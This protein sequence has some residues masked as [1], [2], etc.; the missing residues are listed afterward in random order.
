VAIIAAVT[1][2]PKFISWLFNTV[3][4]T[5]PGAKLTKHDEV[6]WLLMFI[7]LLI[8]ATITD[9]CGT[10]LWGC[11]IA[12][13][14]FATQH[15]AHHVWVRQVKRTTC[16]WLRVFF[17]C[18]LAWSIPVDEL[19]SIDAFW[20]GSIMGIGPCIA[21]KVLCGPFMG[22]ARWVIGWAMVGRAEF[23][24]FIAILAKSLTLMDEKLFAILVWALIYATIF[25]P[26]I[27]RYV[28]V[29][30]MAKLEASEAPKRTSTKQEVEAEDIAHKVSQRISLGDA[31]GKLPNIGAEK[32]AQKKAEEQAE[33]TERQLALETELEQK[34]NRIKELEAKRAQ[35]ESDEKNMNDANAPE[36]P[37]REIT[38]D[39]AEI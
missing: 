15:H 37:P 2:W 24:Y 20:K 38:K 4:E 16:W 8:Y 23:A 39:L 11:F 9:V 10:H 32:L 35:L 5:K 7:T 34:N 27:F 18:T 29:G 19:F 14:S 26:L 21:T 22:D 3:K 25:A 6:M 31:H 12:G 13:M 28:L 33:L 17:G 1:V 30:Y 36:V